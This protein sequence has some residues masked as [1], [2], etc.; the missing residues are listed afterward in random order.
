MSS[1][2]EALA[3]WQLALKLAMTK[4]IAGE[5]RDGVEML[6]YRTDRLSIAFT[7]SKDERPNGLD[8]W[9][10]GD[11]SRKV[12]DVIWTDGTMPMIVTYW[13]GPWERLLKRAV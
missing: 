6:I 10:R 2:K 13:A 11:G 4:G 1:D 8:V 12:L 7:P 9:T 3:L 5:N